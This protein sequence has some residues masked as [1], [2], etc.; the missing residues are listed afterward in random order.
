MMLQN[1]MPVLLCTPTLR[2]HVRK[3][4]E[5]ALPHLTV[6]SLNEVPQSRTIRAFG[7]VETAA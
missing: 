6:L 1:L 7:M 4:T 3:L 2:R 5:R